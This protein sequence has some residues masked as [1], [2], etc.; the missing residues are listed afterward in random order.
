MACL[1]MADWR[2]FLVA[3]LWLAKGMKAA[4]KPNIVEGWS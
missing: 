3:W 2:V 1:H 4:E